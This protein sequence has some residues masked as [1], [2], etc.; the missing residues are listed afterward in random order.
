MENKSVL[1][2]SALHEE[3]LI[4]DIH[5]SIDTKWGKTCKKNFKSQCIMAL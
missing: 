4:M 5:N 1:H 2:F 3:E